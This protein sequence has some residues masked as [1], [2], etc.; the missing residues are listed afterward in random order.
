MNG[1]GVTFQYRVDPLPQ[2]G[3]ATSIVLSFDGITD[4]AGA[5]VQLYSDAGLKLGSAATTRT[6]PAGEVSSWTVEV[7]PAAQGIGYLHVF[8]TQ[9]GTTSSISI[10][11]QVGRVSPT[12]MFQPTTSGIARQAHSMGCALNCL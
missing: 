9:N 6:L 8:T 12:A 1:S 7:V 2:A 4:P 3:Q 5:T 10:R 11:V